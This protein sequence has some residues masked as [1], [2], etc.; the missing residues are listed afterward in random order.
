MCEYLGAEDRGT[1]IQRDVYFDVPQGRLKL[2]EEEGAAPCLIAYERPDLHGEKESRY[3]I[4]EVG[5]AEELREALSTVLGVRIVVTKARRLFILGDLRIH[6]D[7]V[8]G[9]GEFIE[10]EGVI[11]S[12]ES[13]GS[14]RFEALLTELR[15]AFGIREDDLVAESYS[16]LVLTLART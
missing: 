15:G 16:D 2:R 14:A 9:L 12:V 6:F 7:R 1:L 5:D 4:V 11:G 8:D 13:D 3:R 10:F